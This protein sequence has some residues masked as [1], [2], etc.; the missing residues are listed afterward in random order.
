VLGRIA[1]LTY[2][3]DAGRRLTC[4]ALDQGEKPSVVSA[5]LKFY[6]TE[7]MRVVVNDGMD[8]LTRPYR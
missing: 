7:N 5:I 3:M 6:N 4:A 1:G 2:T 8:G